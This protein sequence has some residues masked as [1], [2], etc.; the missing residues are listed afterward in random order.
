MRTTAGG[1]QLAGSTNDTITVST[2]PDGIAACPILT[3]G[4]NP[5]TNTVTATALNIDN[6]VVAVEDGEGTFVEALN[7]VVTFNATATLGAI[8]FVSVTTASGAAFDGTSFVVDGAFINFIA[9]IQNPRS[10]F[11]SANS[12]VI[13]QG[14]VQQGQTR[15]AAGG[16]DLTCAAIG[17]LPNGTCVQN[18]GASA[19]D[20]QSAGA[21]TFVA[22]NAT[23][24]LELWQGSVG[25]TLLVSKSIPITLT[26]TPPTVG[27]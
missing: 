21:G 1:G 13:L 16:T 11:G 26:I 3:L 23:L 5:A 24:V 14:W 17:T 18:S 22:G 27:N 4:P 8:S 2:G 7:S 25:G 19:N 15:R 9:T 12:P 10:A 20:I 6:N